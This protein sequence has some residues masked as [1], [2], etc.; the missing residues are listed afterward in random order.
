[1]SASVGG[2]KRSADGERHKG[3]A[4]REMMKGLDSV[5]EAR[6][7]QLLD[8]G[9]QDVDPARVRSVR[10]TP[11]FGSARPLSD[12]LTAFRIMP[13]PAPPVA[14][15]AAAAA[16]APPQPSSISQRPWSEMPRNLQEMSAAQLSLKA[17]EMFR[18]DTD[19]G[20]F[21]CEALTSKHISQVMVLESYGSLPKCRQS[22]CFGTNLSVGAPLCVYLTR[23]QRAHFEAT[24]QVP[25][26]EYRH[27]LCYICFLYQANM[28]AD[29]VS[30]GSYPNLVARIPFMHPRGPGG[31]VDKALRDASPECQQP[32]HKFD[33]A[34]YH[35][36]DIDVYVPNGIA[37][38]QVDVLWE[39]VTVKALAEDGSLIH[40]AKQ[41][42]D[43]V[44]LAAGS[45][46]AV[47]SADSPRLCDILRDQLIDPTH[48]STMD[49]L[50]LCDM[51]ESMGSTATWPISLRKSFSAKMTSDGR[52]FFQKSTW[53]V[54][55]ATL[56]I[57]NTK[58]TPQELVWAICF[59]ELEVGRAI[60]V[61]QASKF[62]GNVE[63][64]VKELLGLEAGIMSNIEFSSA[65][66]VQKNCP[67]YSH[68]YMW[69]VLMICNVVEYLMTSAYPKELGGPLWSEVVCEKM[70]VPRIRRQMEAYRTYMRGIFDFFNA[71][72]S[73]E[74]DCSD[75][76]LFEVGRNGVLEVINL[77][78]DGDLPC[79]F[80]GAD[81]VNY[82]PVVRA[83]KSKQPSEIIKTTLG[84]DLPNPLAHDSPAVNAAMA[85]AAVSAS[86]KKRA[87][88]YHV[89]SDLFEAT[90]CPLTDSIAAVDRVQQ[91]PDH[92]GDWTPNM[93]PTPLG[94]IQP[95][96]SGELRT[97]NLCDFNLV[98]DYVNNDDCDDRLV[99]TELLTQ[100]F[101]NANEE[102][103]KALAAKQPDTTIW[104]ALV[105]RIRV[106]SRTLDA[107]LGLLNNVN[108]RL[109]A[110]ANKPCA[111]LIENWNAELVARIS[112]AVRGKDHPMREGLHGGAAD[113]GGV[114]D[115]LRDVVPRVLSMPQIDPQAAECYTEQHRLVQAAQALKRFMSSHSPLILA[116]LTARCITNDQC[117]KF[118]LQH[119]VSEFCETSICAETMI[120][121]ATQQADVQFGHSAPR[122]RTTHYTRV[123]AQVVPDSLSAMD[124]ST[125]FRDAVT[126]ADFTNFATE[127]LVAN[128]CGMYPRALTVANYDTWL[129]CYIL[130]Q[131]D[132]RL[133]SEMFEWFVA[134]KEFT[135]ANPTQPG[136]VGKGKGRGAAAGAAR[137]SQKAPEFHTDSAERVFFSALRENYITMCSQTPLRFYI[138]SVYPKYT[139]FERSVLDQ[140]DSVRFQMKGKRC[141]MT[142]Y[143]I[144][145][146]LCHSSAL[147]WHTFHKPPAHPFP[148]F[149]DCFREVSLTLMIAACVQRCEK[150][151]RSFFEPSPK[152]LFALEAFV[153]HI[154]TYRNFDKA[155]L[156]AM[157]VSQP[158]ADSMAVVIAQHQKGILT[159][160]SGQEHVRRL[161]QE[162]AHDYQLCFII[163]HLLA[164]RW[165]TA[166][167]RLDDDTARR[168]AK[169]ISLRPEL[170]NSLSSRHAIVSPLLCCFEIRT[171][172]RG[173][174]IGTKP[175]RWNLTTNVHTCVMP[176]S[177]T[178]SSAR[179]QQTQKKDAVSQLDVTIEQFKRSKE[180]GF[181]A[182]HVKIAAKM[183]DAMR[184]WAQL[185]MKSLLKLPCS[186]CPIDMV[187][188][189][190]YVYVH[191]VSATLVDTCTV[192]P[193]CGAMTTFEANQFGL[194]G[195]S[196]GKCQPYMLEEYQQLTEDQC[197]KCGGFMTSLATESRH[198]GLDKFNWMR[199]VIR[200]P[201]VDDCSIP[202]MAITRPVSICKVCNAWWLRDAQST[203]TLG[204]R[205]VLEAKK[206]L[207]DS[208]QL[209]NVIGRP[210]ADEYIRK[211]K[212]ARNAGPQHRTMPKLI[213]AT[214]IAT[215]QYTSRSVG[216][217]KLRVE[218][219]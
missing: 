122:D 94:W 13:S 188:V 217:M 178:T 200:Q 198:T 90:F 146:T 70:R 75:Q 102:L 87:I 45:M 135:V 80:E 105:M 16:L 110:I 9:Q 18:D 153:K 179:Q 77:K 76:R 162:S 209:V 164:L 91:P 21:E 210:N 160:A 218:V 193:M 43:L 44:N 189:V 216:S 36:V 177:S 71:A 68:T 50:A 54:E 15:S 56:P 172:I 140:C 48:L 63:F 137:K 159:A 12:M 124:F 52:L 136:A 181:S 2:I 96:R 201:Y 1:M 192:C 86:R 203:M 85:A 138:L 156:T 26:E 81:A 23:K 170:N 73:A 126:N 184:S 6:N 57:P 41:C 28:L 84:P 58:A 173:M 183:N 104:R 187:P 89:G 83:V 59:S 144:I 154:P 134:S 99:D 142:E 98:G 55:R 67:F 31:W 92:P 157:G 14:Q 167:L 53:Y 208:E 211:I 19:L 24:G 49:T 32:L 11:P 141:T 195:F 119:P 95:Y 206:S 150:L 133:R 174:M 151:P 155:W 74:R 25:A 190:G 219:L 29:V 165:R 182:E 213:S 212:G 4:N 10:E 207:V 88:P 47:A 123:M 78:F 171:F 197:I 143:D 42:P 30:D 46:H 64:V 39:R 152:L 82:K 199:P 116:L 112:E 114:V 120:S 121:T 69:L 117:K 79:A 111:F 180:M 168:Q 149:D 62:Q 27:K 93:S 129:D 37:S 169:A 8:A 131:A 40:G 148:F 65:A 191:R 205:A 109:G 17:L 33:L 100:M 72:V 161:H 3:K 186:D 194:N 35:A 166:Y 7:R 175:V 202:G 127:C 125:A 132:V 97:L 34:D 147:P 115:L 107:V 66:H 130:W 185:L 215:R 22:P 38:N 20:P 196:C 204:Q 113:H 103:A 51:Q 163:F 145:M 106:A 108:A 158:A 101:V 176:K 60:I 5:Y 118:L 61:N 214:E 128:I 139:E